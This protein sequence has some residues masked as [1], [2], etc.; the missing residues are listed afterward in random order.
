MKLK[1]IIA[2]AVSFFIL[3]TPVHAFL[4]IEGRAAILIDQG[5]GT[6]L[7]AHNEHE[8]MFPAGLAKIMT[9][10]IVLDF[11]D[12]QEV[13]VIGNEI[14]NIPSGA[15]MS[16]HQIG[17]HITVHNLLRGLMIRNG[18]D[19]GAVLA[20]NT[21]RRERNNN[22]V[23]YVNA[24]Q[25][26][27]NLMNERA[28]ELGAL[29][30]NFTNPNG[31][32]NDEL[33]TTAY[34]LAII[35]RAFMQIPLLAE[36]AAETVFTGSGLDGYLGDMYA[37]ADAFVVQHNWVEVNELV[38]GGPFFFPHAT[39]IRSGTTPQ[40][41]DNV[42]ASATFDDVQLI[43]IVFYSPDPGRWNDATML[44]NYGFA[45][46]SYFD[47]VESDQHIETVHIANA[48]LGEED[49][50]DI[51]AVGGFRALFSQEQFDSIESYIVFNELLLYTPDLDPETDLPPEPTD[52][53]TLL[54]PIFEN[55]VVGSI[56]FTL[57]GQILFTTDLIAQSTVEARTL[58]TDMDFYI[59]LVIETLFSRTALPYW[60][61]GVGTMTGLTGIIL[62]V[63]ERRKRH[64]WYGRTM[65]KY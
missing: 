31:L 47:V 11:L 35:A 30:T 52:Y 18:N 53:I 22:N 51:T 21:V 3:I 45:T 44:F 50:V 7:F 2:M 65:R 12:P 33:F 15:L 14:L 19:S 8:R 25:I 62:A 41:S 42:A 61:A 4:P 59:A 23:P 58:D 43:A 55:D 57:G 46:Y 39:G 37:F 38:I 48:V 34:D 16:G 1:S 60:I 20:L 10:I 36:I 28:A 32:H 64:P 13:I 29:D 63:R 9:A 26:F 49:T 40:A 54:A 56:T 27:S 5:E 6:V 17:E 24:I